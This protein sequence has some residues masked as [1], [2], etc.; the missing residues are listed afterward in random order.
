MMMPDQ[1]FVFIVDDDP[2]CEELWKAKAGAVADLVRTADKL[3]IDS[4]RF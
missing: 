3:A 4:T 1:Y 2:P